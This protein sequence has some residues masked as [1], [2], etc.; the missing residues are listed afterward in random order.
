MNGS[1]LTWLLRE[2]FTGGSVEAHV[3]FCLSQ[4][5]PW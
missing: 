3:L 5:K 2:L 4:G 1:G